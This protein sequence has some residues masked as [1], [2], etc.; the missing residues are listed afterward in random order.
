MQNLEIST[1]SCYFSTKVQ[2]VSETK[3]ISLENIQKSRFLSQKRSD[4]GSILHNKLQMIILLLALS[5]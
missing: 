1:E 3:G 5:I 2:K 4:I